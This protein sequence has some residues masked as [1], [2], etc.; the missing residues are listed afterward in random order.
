[1]HI[2]TSAILLT[3]INSQL[4]LADFFLQT[5][6]LSPILCRPLS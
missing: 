2:K 1:V 6:L 3:V 4:L 5:A